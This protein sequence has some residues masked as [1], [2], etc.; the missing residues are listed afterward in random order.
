[1]QMASPQSTHGR[2]VLGMASTRRRSIVK[3]N[4]F[5]LPS[6]NRPAHAAASPTDSLRPAVDIVGACRRLHAAIDR[7]EERVADAAG[8]SL[9]DLR[10]LNLLEL[11]PLPATAIAR[12]LHLATGSVTALIDRL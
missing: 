10:Y 3:L 11:G 8:I 12:Q 9:S 6:G 2:A 4:F 1:M 5:N 7:L